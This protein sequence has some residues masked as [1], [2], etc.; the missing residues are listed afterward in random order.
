M[1]VGL[2]SIRSPCA[3]QVPVLWQSMDAWLQYLS[4]AMGPLLE[5]VLG[6][7]EE[8]TAKCQRDVTG[9]LSIQT[10]Q[11][12]PQPVSWSHKPKGN[13]TGSRLDT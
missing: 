8:N 1:R 7:R 2:V 4:A 6:I 10:L 11:F 13:M 5:P 9:L 12:G 3:F